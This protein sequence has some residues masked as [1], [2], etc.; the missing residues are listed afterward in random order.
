MK[1]LYLCRMKL[2]IAELQKKNKFSNEE[3]GNK[4]NVSDQQV[5]NYK[6]SARMPP[7]KTLEK[8]ADAFNCEFIELFEAPIGYIHDYDPDTGEWLGIRK[9]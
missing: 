5:S 2:R 6:T 9:K 3:L 7:L 4:I 8:I 1:D